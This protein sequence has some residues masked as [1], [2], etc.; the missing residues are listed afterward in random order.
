MFVCC[1]LL[2]LL[3]SAHHL[4]VFGAGWVFTWSVEGP[5]AAR[6]L[7]VADVGRDGAALFQG[8]GCDKVLNGLFQF[9]FDI[10]RR[11]RST[12]R[13]PIIP[14]LSNHTGLSFVKLF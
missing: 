8:T 9:T 4:L 7:V 11:W 2:G 12:L 13:G 3:G 6:A 14:H 1:L 5:R 10:E